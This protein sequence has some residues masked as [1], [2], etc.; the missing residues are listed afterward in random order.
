MQQESQLSDQIVTQVF[1]VAPNKFLCGIWGEAAAYLCVKGEK[2][3]IKINCPTSEETQCTD[4]VEVPEFNFKSNPYVLMRNNKALN[5]I[6]VANL[7]IHR[8]TLT[9]NQRGSTPKL[10]LVQDQKDSLS[11]QIIFSCIGGQVR[12]IKVSRN[13]FSDLKHCASR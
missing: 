3:A 13:F 7:K 1:E 8:L 9:D 4:L 2:T 6:D 5:L 10:C 12:E 11:Y